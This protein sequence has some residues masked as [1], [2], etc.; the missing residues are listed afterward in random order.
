MPCR[1]RGHGLDVE[2]LG[3][4]FLEASATGIPVLVGDSGGAPETVHDGVTGIVVDGRDIDQ[5]ATELLRF[6]AS[7]ERRTSFGRTVARGCSPPGNGVC[8]AGNSAAF[9]TETLPTTRR[10]E[11]NGP[12]YTPFRSP[13]SPIYRY[14]QMI[15]PSSSPT[16]LSGPAGSPTFASPSPKTVGPG[17]RWTATGAVDGTS[18]IWLESVADGTNLHYFLHAAPSGTGSPA[19]QAKRA[20]SLTTFYRFRFK[21]L[22]NELRQLLDS[23]RPAGEDPLQ[24][25]VEHPRAREIHEELPAS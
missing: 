13:T 25:R 22:V 7:A 20:A 16:P 2:G 15:L 17:L 5:V 23:D 8:S 24:W 4:V 12:W 21:D 14:P 3:I 19:T 11:S 1:T 9:S 18:E 6:L 10:K